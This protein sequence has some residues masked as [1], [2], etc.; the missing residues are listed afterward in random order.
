MPNQTSKI[1]QKIRSYWP[2]EDLDQI[3][4]LLNQ[5]GSEEYERE[6]PR[7]Q[8]AILKL[9]GGDLKQIP[10]LVEMARTDYRDLLAYAEYPEEMKTDYKLIRQM[11]AEEVGQLRQRDRQQYLDWL[12]GQEE[13][14][15]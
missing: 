15:N 12:N 11:G 8:L 6:I 2:D 4:A 7:V 14:G 13:P 9:S 10:R 3:L 1:H 5:Y